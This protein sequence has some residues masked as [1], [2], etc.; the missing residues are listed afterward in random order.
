MHNQ[1]EI[2]DLGSFTID[3]PPMWD[4]HFFPR[5]ESKVRLVKDE[6]ILIIEYF[7]VPEAD[8]ENFIDVFYEDH[9]LDLQRNINGVIFV[10]EEDT[11]Y[12]IL[13]ENDGE[14]RKYFFYGHSRFI[15]RFTLSGLWEPEDEDDI[16]SM[17]KNL[18]INADPTES[19]EEIILASFNFDYQDWF[20]FGAMYSR[21][22]GL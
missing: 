19:T 8:S 9:I 10:D 6:T 5:I 13:F 21:R 7:L 12:E 16:R 3:L 14:F 17:L 4:A 2:L 20:K 11:E 1:L 15:F 18:S 22:G